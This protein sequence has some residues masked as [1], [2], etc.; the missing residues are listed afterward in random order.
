MVKSIHITLLLKM[1]ETITL[2]VFLLKTNIIMSM[3]S[4]KNNKCQCD[5]SKRHQSWSKQTERM[6][7][8]RERKLKLI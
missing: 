7:T 8:R 5:I 2:A 4:K 1:W 6:G 3:V